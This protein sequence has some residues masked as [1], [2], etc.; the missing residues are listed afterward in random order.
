MRWRIDLSYQ[1]TNYSGWQ[2][3]PGDKTVQQTIEEAFGVVLRAP[4]EITGCGRTDTGVHARKY[5]AH[6]DVQGD[7]D[8]SKILYQ[9]NA[10][11]PDD[12]AIR[13]ISE[14][15][16]NFHARFD[17]IQ[18]Q[19]NYHIHFQKDPFLNKQS[20]YFH[21][22]TAL[23]HT[24]IAN[25]ASLLKEYNEF[26]PFCKTGSDIKH[27]RCELTMSDWVFTE[28]NAIYSISANRFL[29]GMVR[30][31]TGTLLNI[32]LGKLTWE[33]VEESL[34][35]KIPLPVQWSVPAQG[36]YLAEVKY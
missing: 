4:I 28:D 24:A 18:R 25:A 30:L 26:L 5:T 13:S 36:L 17:A 31:I 23:D 12:I 10:V 20:F 34:K 7:H 21:Q 19:Y 11:L 35:N 33:V 32:G 15:D 16:E 6:L 8:I 9:V 2:K 29:R 22:H 1:G 3:Q 14:V 27:Y